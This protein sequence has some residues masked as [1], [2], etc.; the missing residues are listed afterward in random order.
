MPR[1]FMFYHQIASVLRS[2]VLR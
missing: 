1:R 2:S